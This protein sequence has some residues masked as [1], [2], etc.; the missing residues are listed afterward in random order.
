[1]SAFNREL[2]SEDTPLTICAKY[3]TECPRAKFVIVGEDGVQSTH[4]MYRA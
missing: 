2:T 4:A 1:M 3:V